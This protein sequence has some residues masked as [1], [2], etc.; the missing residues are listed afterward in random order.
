MK[1]D[2]LVEDDVP[3]YT[4]NKRR[5]QRSKT[6]SVSED[7]DTGLRSFKT[8]QEMVRQDEDAEFVGQ[9]RDGGRGL[10][11]GA[12]ARGPGRGGRGR[13]G[14]RGRSGAAARGR[15]RGGYSFADGNESARAAAWLGG[16]NRRG[17]QT[18]RDFHNNN[19]GEQG[20]AL[21]DD[22]FDGGRP[23][24]GR[25]EQSAGRRSGRDGRGRGGSRSG[26]RGG[27][28]WQEGDDPWTAGN[29]SFGEQNRPPPGMG[30]GQRRT[31]GYTG[32]PTR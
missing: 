14:G 17:G 12:A 28:S 31:G 16:G 8:I 2:P 9:R 7:N 18:R 25:W 32:R 20:G 4:A 24:G 13:V 27:D 15:G 1:N 19:W 22:E 6:G 21:S 26:G 3:L 5:A 23:R 30:G 29:S 10:P 11:E